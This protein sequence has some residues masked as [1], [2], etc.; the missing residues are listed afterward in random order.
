[1]YSTTITDTSQ[2][3]IDKSGSGRP[4][5]WAQHRTEAEILSIAYA[6]IDPAKMDRLLTCAPRLTFA[7]GAAD[8]S[9]K[10]RLAAAWFCRVRLCPICQWRRSLKIYGQ[11]AEI[12]RA[13]NTSTPGG[14]AWLML[15]L[16]VRNVPG[17]E[18]SQ[19][20]TDMGKAWHRLIKLDAWQRVV[21]GTMRSTEVTHNTDPQSPA[22]DT[23]HPH[24]HV[25]LCVRRSYFKAR[26]YLS[27]D[28]WAALWQRSVRCS[29]TP[30][31]WISRVKGD[32]AAA[33]AEVA[34]YATKPSDY[35]MPSD[36]DMMQ[37]TVAVLDKALNKRRLV[38]WTGNLKEIRARLQLD[39]VEDG[40]LVHTSDT[41]Q[42]A[43]N[44]LLITY[45]WLR[46]RR[47]YY[48]EVEIDAE[49]PEK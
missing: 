35:I 25:L 24:M 48:K 42:D 10:M 21:L 3:L 20:I 37:S 5:P 11:A 16:T 7:Q 44:H 30:Q 41:E 14:Y 13:A 49:T 15:T 36:V 27:R 1:M 26:D 38:A 4:Q 40:D 18:L 43:D 46:E 2:P 47:N 29:Y 33:L 34:K 8:G 6:D 17:N 45:N 9:D 23:Y 32:T 28:D 19:T 22:Y 12:I 31:V 39:D